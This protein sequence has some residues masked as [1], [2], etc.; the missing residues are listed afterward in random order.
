MK[1]SLWKSQTNNLSEAK[2]HQRRRALV[3]TKK[4]QLIAE[5]FS[6][7]GEGNRTHTPL[8]TRS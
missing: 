7:A 5:L 8:G 2:A 1:Y 3:P 4:A 6:S